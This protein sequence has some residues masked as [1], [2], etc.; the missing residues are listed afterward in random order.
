M[1]E[2]D[3]SIVVESK[4]FTWCFNMTSVQTFSSPALWV[5]ADRM[6]RAER[7]TTARVHPSSHDGASIL[8]SSQ[9]P[10]DTDR[11]ERGSSGG[12]DGRRH[13]A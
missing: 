11:G 4:G 3:E 10:S 1:V 12:V 9:R 8:Y 7:S 6:K 13:D 5:K 2:Q